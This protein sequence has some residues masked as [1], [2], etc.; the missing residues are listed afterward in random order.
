MSQI[1]WRHQLRP[2]ARV[3]IIMRTGE[4]V[5]ILSSSLAGERQSERA[6]DRLI[7][8]ISAAHIEPF[9]TL[10]ERAP[11]VVAVECFGGGAFGPIVL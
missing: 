2:L 9:I 3:A 6:L 8:M 10:D 5:D 4:L 7:S 11:I 1:A